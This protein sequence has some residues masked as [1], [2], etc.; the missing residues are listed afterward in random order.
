MGLNKSGVARGLLDPEWDWSAG[1]FWPV[2]KAAQ[3]M[4]PGQESL[5]FG[6]LEHDDTTWE[7]LKYRRGHS[8]A[9]TAASII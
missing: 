3:V 2:W 4:S 9:P 5:D 8:V 7:Q 1:L 6:D